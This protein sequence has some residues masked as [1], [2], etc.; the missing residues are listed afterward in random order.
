[1][2]VLKLGTMLSDT[3]TKTKGMLTHL[4]IHIG[5]NMEY[6]YQPHGLDPET[7]KPVETLW[8]QAERLIGGLY[9]ELD[10]PPDLLGTKAED[11]ATG[12]KGKIIS[13]IY[14]LNGCLHVEIKPEGVSA[15]NATF[16]SHEFDIRRVK[17]EKIKPLKAKALEKSIKETPSPIP[18]TRVVKH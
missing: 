14:H 1:M 6:I 12:F 10:V 4:I 8:L 13:L 15:K 5:G 11:I 7:M 18:F 9:E 2:K 3:I 17:G 16:A